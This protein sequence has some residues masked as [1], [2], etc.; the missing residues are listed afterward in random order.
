MAAA[1]QGGAIIFLIEEDDDTRPL[2]KAN[3][4]RDGY[5]VQISVDEED[6]M[7]RVR[8]GGQRA[9]LILVNLIGKPP[10][11]VL[12]VGRRIREHGKYDPS[13]PLVIMA[14][15]YGENL[16]GTDAQVG[17]Y[18]WITYPEDGEQLHGLLAR[19][20]KKSST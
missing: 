7:D 13:T 8:D 4:Q 14:E 1:N 12:E 18:D 2:L 5:Q 17:E 16:E 19:L 11:E 6:A 20:L 9:D 3:L 15:K 10:E